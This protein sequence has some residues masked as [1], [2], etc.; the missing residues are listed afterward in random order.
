LLYIAGSSG[1]WSQ[2]GNQGRLPYAS[3][4]SLVSWA[5]S[6]L[7]GIFSVWVLQ[8]LR[9]WLR[10][11]THCCCLCCVHTDTGN[12]RVATLNLDTL[13]LTT[14]VGNGTSG[15]EDTRLSAPEG[16]AV[17]AQGGVWVADTANHVSP[18]TGP[19]CCPKEFLLQCSICLNG[20]LLPLIACC[21]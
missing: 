20:S 2:L 8:L 11:R 6:S 7:E 5:V 4:C 3:P 21:Y 19:C 17:D 14:L 1:S 18:P 15:T 12:H 16:V 10:C 9:A 13:E